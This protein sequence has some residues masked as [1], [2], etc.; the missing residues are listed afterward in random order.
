MGWKKTA[1][2]RDS[3][4]QADAIYEDFNERG[5][6]VDEAC[7]WISY[8]ATK[9]ATVHLQSTQK[10]KKNNQILCMMVTDNFLSFFCVL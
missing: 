5:I 4:S 10:Y 2:K 9:R 7:S 6:E 3:P 8:Q 1:K